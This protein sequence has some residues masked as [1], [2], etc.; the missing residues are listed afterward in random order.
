ERFP[1]RAPAGLQQ[2]PAAGLS[3]LASLGEK[4]E[5]RAATR[6]NHAFTVEPRENSLHVYNGTELRRYGA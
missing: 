2:I 6:L 1:R 3:A 4:T 5:A